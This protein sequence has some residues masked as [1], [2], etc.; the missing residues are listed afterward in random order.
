[1]TPERWQ[2]VKDLFRS[3][4]ERD[5]GERAA[6]LE[7]ACGG[8]EG[9]RREVES[10][11][12]SY[13]DSDT[14]ME[15]PVAG[16]AASLLREE[17]ADD[18]VGR[19]L[20][21]YEVAALIGEGGM[22][23]VYL[24]R[25]AKLGRKVALKLLPGE[26]TAD[27]ERLRRFEQEARAASSLNHP[28]ILT[29]YEVGEAAGARY[30]AAEFVEGET[31]RERLARAP[32]SA[33]EA[34][35]LGAQVAS[36]LAAAHEAGIVHRD[37]KPENLIVRRDS[38]VK[39]L[40][41]GLAKLATP[42]TAVVDTEAATRI[43][44]DTGLGVVLG[45]VRYMSPEQAR[46]IGTDARTDIWSLGCVLYEMV[47]GH[48]PFEG[49]TDSDVIAAI[50]EREPPPLARYTSDVP[51]ELEWIVR[52]ALRKN[53]EERY[54]AAK[55]LFTDLKSLKRR[56]EFEAELGRG[57]TPERSA[58]VAARARGRPF[59]RPRIIAAAT[60]ILLALA[61]P[62]WQPWR[63]PTEAEP[64][65]AVT[66]TTLPGVESHPSL[67]PDGGH[68]AFAWGGAKQ[69][70]Q[71]I[72]V[73]MIG[74]GSPL[75]LTSDPRH[76]Y[77]PVWSPDGRWIAF[78]RSEP[79]APT[80]PRS[81][82]L[83]LIAP[84]G[85]PERKLADVRGQD[86]FPAASYLA[87][88]P[89]SDS[90]VVT[91][92]AGEGQPDALFVV[93][94][95]TG[96]KRPLTNPRPPALA[97]ISPA[98][99]PDG[100]SLVFL[101]RTSWGSGELR[102]L[103]LGESLTAA[104]EP[105]LLTPAELRADYPAWT[106]DGKE[107]VFSARGNL[108]RLAVTGD[109]APRRVPYVGEDGLMPTISR[110]QPG[111][112]ARLVYVRSFSDENFWLI[113]T[114]APG[115]PALSAPATAISSTRHEYHCRFSPDGGRV[116]FGSGRSGEREIW[117]SDPD[118][119]DAVQLTS[120]GA[121][122]T[123]CPDWSPDG[124]LIAFSSNPEGEFDIYVVPAAGGK[125]R[126]LTSDPAI[127]ICPTFSQDGKW[128]YFPSMRSGDY[129]VWKMP[130]AGGE[131]VQVTPNQGGWAYEAPDGASIYYVTPSVVSPVWR[132]PISGGEPV[133]VLDGVVW[134]NFC[135]LE[136]GAY[137]IDRLG[138]ETRLQHLDFETG[139]SATVARNLGEVSA[140]LTA[141]PDGRKILFTRVDA[142][143]DDLML[144]EDFR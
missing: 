10:L 40:D 44:V 111:K 121:Q 13:S 125:P 118:G 142:S 128:L 74:Q 70:N 94:L 115:A 28:N 14:F 62:F 47:G 56:L 37:I 122:E 23:R 31:L 144:V 126:R 59:L 48:A 130:A 45:T 98:V 16:A 88:S 50:L 135:L 46:G 79:P 64:L 12:E 68:V 83:R 103:S 73:Q 129:R 110:S 140:G 102:L 101:R 61:V 20:G 76:D 97:D 99:S 11:L 30:I 137:Y 113:E 91:D 29:I 24:A 58:D 65:R 17:Q 87:W 36:A 32:L 104:G 7:R 124:Q 19:R 34:L 60:L 63:A 35:D 90:L 75:R 51:A 25:D 84:L 141:S 105:A 127:D 22:G 49:E 132:L 72:Y 107:I 136:K 123:M 5:A 54:Q 117:V 6:F 89:E 120:L 67:S 143:V 26:F 3:A 57:A 131:A 109:S 138:G 71:D 66:L 106:P 108:W 21:R 38:I 116:A 55:E 133:K 2:R 139:R 42:Q 27:E 100:R 53:R 134:F 1:V 4:L 8:D 39:V 86:F 33:A 82:E 41:F 93:S 69:D 112:P 92:S 81:R 77:N 9:L 18:L 80:G 95:E 85:G 96:E 15:T 52:K 119:S 43:R 78:F 114:S